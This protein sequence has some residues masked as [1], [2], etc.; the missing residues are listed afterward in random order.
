[1]MLNFL[2]NKATDE[3]FSILCLGAH[4]DDIEIGC[5]GTILRL[6]NEFKRVNISWIIFSGNTERA[7]EAYASADAFLRNASEKKVLIKDFKDTHFPYIGAQIKDFFEQKI[8]LFSPEL[9]FTHFRNDAHQDH[10][11]INELTWNTFRNTTIL[12]YEIPKYDGDLGFPNIYIDLDE[13]I[14]KQKVD[15]LIDFYKSQSDKRWF[16][17]DTFHSLLRLR[18]VESNAPHRCSEAFFGRKVLL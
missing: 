11:V 14:C 6:L 1:M 13:A 10:R 4:C 2:F 5:G 3:E 9:I 7:S 18:G 12:E 16:S 17:K 15:Y 8:K